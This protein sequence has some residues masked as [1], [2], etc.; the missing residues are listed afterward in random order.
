MTS[1][2]VIELQNMLR[3]RY[4]SV[5]IDI[6]HKHFFAKLHEVLCYRIDPIYNLPSKALKLKLSL[7]QKFFETDIY[8]LLSLQLVL[9]F[10]M[11]FVGLDGCTLYVEAVN[12][13]SFR[14][15]QKLSECRP[16]L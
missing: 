8:V 16:S 12:A 6:S 14:T 4:Q 3:L 2:C 15:M 9:S 7:I 1:L 11:K 5:Q 10:D 13:W